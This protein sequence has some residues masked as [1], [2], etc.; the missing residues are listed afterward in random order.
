MTDSAVIKG[1]Q[2]VCNDYHQTDEYVYNSGFGNDVL[3]SPTVALGSIGIFNV[4]QNGIFIRKDIKVYYTD[5]NHYASKPVDKKGF[6]TLES[7]N[8]YYQADINSAIDI[9]NVGGYQTVPLYAYNYK[10]YVAD[11]NSAKLLG[12]NPH[13][14][15]YHSHG[16]NEICLSTGIV[17]GLLNTQEV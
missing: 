16:R 17:Y 3:L 11:K 14:V 4:Y 10:L 12:S 5:G 9:S 15:V 8:I 2:I 1:Q 7:G 6:I 13:G